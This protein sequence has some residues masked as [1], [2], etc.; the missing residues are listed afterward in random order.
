ML[1]TAIDSAQ[2]RARLAKTALT[3]MLADEEHHTVTRDFAKLLFGDDVNVEVALCENRPSSVMMFCVYS[4]QQ[5]AQ[6]LG[7]SN[8]SMEWSRKQKDREE[9]TL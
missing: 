2:A 8:S 6:K 4:S 9:E 5:L 1:S 7:I 3:D